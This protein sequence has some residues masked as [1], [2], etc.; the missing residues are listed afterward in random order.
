MHDILTPKAD[1]KLCIKSSYHYFNR[2][3]AYYEGG[4]DEFVGSWGFERV[5]RG[6]RD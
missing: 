5:A 6:W 1:E 4:I 3:L 2:N